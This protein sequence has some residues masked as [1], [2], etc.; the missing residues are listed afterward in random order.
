VRRLALFL[1]I[2]VVAFGPFPHA[3]ATTGSSNGSVSY[4]PPVDGPVVQ[5]FDLPRERW[6]AGNRGIDYQPGAGTSVRAAADGEVVFAGQVGGALHVAVLHADGIRTSYSFLRS[7]AVRRG[8]RV[9]QGQAVGTSADRLHFGA[10]VGDT[11]IDPSSL[12][13]GGGLPEVFLVPDEVRRAAS[14]AAER[15]GLAR[16]LSAAARAMGDAA[17]RTAGFPQTAIEVGRELARDTVDSV[18]TGVRNGVTQKLDELR[19]ALHYTQLL[20]GAVHVVRV[21]RTTA[22]W[23]HQRRDCTPA[24]VRPPPLPERRMAVL[25]SG[26]GSTSGQDAIDDLDTA[27]LGYGPGD[28]VRFSY[29]GGTVSE[30]TYDADDTT[31]DIRTSARR[32]RELLERIHRDHPGMPVD[33]IAH[34][35]GGVVAQTAMAYEYDRNDPRLPRVSNVVTL[36]SPHQ[37]SDIATA[38]RMVGHTTSGELVEAALHETGLTS[39]D[40][41]A[42][43][44]QQISETSTFLA[45]LNRRPLAEGVRLTSIGARGDFI[46]PAVHTRVNGG[47]NVVVSVPGA[48]TDHGRLPGSQAAQREVALAVAGLPP[49]CQTLTDMLADTLVSGAISTAEDAVGAALYTGGTLL[50]KRLQPP[51]P[52]RRP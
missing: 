39:F 35:Q 40:V 18:V 33:I 51:K 4:L 43:S 7:I 21:A 48:F 22:D 32:L 15:S 30:Q 47:Q 36:A 28:V 41:R 1:A 25:V 26:L 42:R 24:G 13:A 45:E 46:N 34:S 29:R 9:R 11:Y 5:S 27:A 16:F 19:G 37:G 23:W 50:D 10:R 12:F 6:Q 49:T 44:V 14:E 3:S 17:R 38:L 2:A 52:R 8:D 20:H 31:V